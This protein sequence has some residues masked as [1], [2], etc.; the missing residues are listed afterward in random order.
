MN[1]DILGSIDV[2]LEAVGFGM[3]QV[4]AYVKKIVNHDSQKADNIL[5]FVQEHKL[6]GG[7]VRIPI[8]LDAICYS[9]DRAVMS[10]NE[11]KTLTS[12]YQAITLK[13]WQKDVLKLGISESETRRH[14]NEHSI[15]SLSAYQIQQL[16][17]SEIY[18]LD[19]IAFTG[20]YNEIIEFN[21]N[22]RHRIYDSLKYQGI[23]LPD[24]PETI[25]RKI[26]FLHTSD[27]TFLDADKSCHFLHPTLQHFFA[28][29]YFAGCW[30]RHERLLCIRLRQQ[31]P[32]TTF[33]A[34][35]AL[36][37]KEKYS[38]RYDTLW[39]FAAGL[40]QG[41]PKAE[42]EAEE[43]IQRYF[44]ELAAEPLDLLGSVHHRLLMNCLGEVVPDVQSNWDRELVEHQIYSWVQFELNFS[45]T[46]LTLP[47]TEY[48]DSHAIKGLGQQPHLPPAI[49][50]TCFSSCVMVV[51][52]IK[53]QLREY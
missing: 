42:H 18:L 24:L 14:L 39:R 22:D 8:Q 36:L 44:Q 47:Y 11:P 6:I 26:S 46:R 35:Q 1:V 43:P 15:H 41:V 53:K 23:V 13:L 27:V 51:E 48:L 5:A 3:E 12:L 45:N 21:A 30:M 4:T 28:A 10:G 40:L 34:P 31:T 33:M 32:N 52:M 37:Q 20:I 25:L 9:W 16:A 29:R 50:K 38:T 17:P 7:L 19:I 49:L 2:E